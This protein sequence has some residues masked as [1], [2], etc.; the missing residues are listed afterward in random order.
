MKQRLR[1]QKKKNH[2]EFRQQM[3]RD[4]ANQLEQWEKNME[5][6]LRKQAQM[7]TNACKYIEKATGEVQEVSKDLDRIRRNTLSEVKSMKKGRSLKFYGVCFGAALAG[8]LVAVI[9]CG[10][11]WPTI[12]SIL[13]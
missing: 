6:R 2:E 13:G 10:L 11:Y 7:F 5:A 4:V 12:R 1:E 8:A 3:V 9:I